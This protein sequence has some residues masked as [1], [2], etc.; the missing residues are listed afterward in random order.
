MKYRT[1]TYDEKSIIDV[2]L[3][4]WFR[5]CQQYKLTESFITKYK[6]YVDWSQVSRFQKLSESF[7][8]K[9][10]DYVDW[11]FITKRQKLSCDFLDKLFDLIYDK[12]NEE[13]YH[14]LIS[15]III[16]QRLKPWFID[17]YIDRLMKSNYTYIFSNETNLDDILRCQRHLKFDYIIKLIDNDRGDNGYIK[18]LSK[19]LYYHK[20]P[21]DFLEQLLKENNFNDYYRRSTFFNNICQ[22][23]N[24]TEKFMEKYITEINFEL[25]SGYQEFSFGFYDLH[26]DKLNK[27]KMYYN[28]K[29]KWFKKGCE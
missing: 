24:L 6:D 23:Q 16:H 28:K 22:T 5:F 17:K 3:I 15:N 12:V 20:V 18:Y 27:N 14:I 25:I 26:K 9:H 4:D 8:E 21:M 7:I 2:N 10:K 13:N 19:L 29:L 11:W 1:I